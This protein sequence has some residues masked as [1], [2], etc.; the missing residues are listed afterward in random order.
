MEASVCVR[1]GLQ[2]FKYPVYLTSATARL[3][4]SGDVV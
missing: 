2:G 3:L 4:P 1:D